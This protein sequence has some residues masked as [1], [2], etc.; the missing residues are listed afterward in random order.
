M[1]KTTV[2]LVLLCL[3]LLSGCMSDG[4]GNVFLKKDFSAPIGRYT[5][6]VVTMDTGNYPQSIADAETFRT[7]LVSMLGKYAVFND[8]V[9]A[10]DAKG[11]KNVVLLK[12]E[13]AEYNKID[14]ITRFMVGSMAGTSSVKVD[15]ELRDFKTKESLGV[16]ETSGTTP[17]AMIRAIETAADLAAQK[18]S[19][20]KQ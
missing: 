20:L 19:G 15:I 2:L 6:A 4:T 13:M 18:L 11:M 14:E 10:E 8:I 5:A 7:Y 17:Q 12:C 16:V 1:K 3:V 9:S